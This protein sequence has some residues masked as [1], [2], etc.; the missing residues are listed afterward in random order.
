MVSIESA[1]YCSS[2]CMFLLNKTIVFEK[3]VY[4]LY[5]PLP[6]AVDDYGT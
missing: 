4:I 2:S 5:M 3:L 1:R 6:C